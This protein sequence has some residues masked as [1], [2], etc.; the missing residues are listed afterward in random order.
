[1][2]T[3][4]Q[5]V[6]DM[7]YKSSNMQAKV[8]QYGF[9]DGDCFAKLYGDSAFTWEGIALY[10]DEDAQKVVDFFEEQGFLTDNPRHEVVLYKT[11]GLDFNR[12]YKLTGDNRYP[13]D[14]TIVS[15][16]LYYLDISNMIPIQ[17]KFGARWFDDIVDNNQRREDEAV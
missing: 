8:K 13:S 1:M 10:D 2:K 7:I 11:S 15:I 3:A 4:K 14:L 9:K 6:N 16:P 17:L 5:Q 12:F